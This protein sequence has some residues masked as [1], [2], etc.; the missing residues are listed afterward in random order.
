MISPHLATFAFV[1]QKHKD[2]VSVLKFSAKSMFF[3]AIVFHL[4]VVKLILK[5]G[6]W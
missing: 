1:V 6:N 4:L 3:W 5:A 2:P